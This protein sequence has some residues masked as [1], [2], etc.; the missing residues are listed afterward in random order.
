[1]DRSFGKLRATRN[2]SVL[3]LDGAFST[4]VVVFGA[5]SWVNLPYPERLESLQIRDAPCG[6]MRDADILLV[7]KHGG[8]ST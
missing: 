2:I 5:N 3:E 7:I 1:M 8:Y 6:N 4:L